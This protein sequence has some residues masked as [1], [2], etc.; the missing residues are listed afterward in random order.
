MSH[1]EKEKSKTK[2]A[3]RRSSAPSPNAFINEELG[4]SQYYLSYRDISLTNTDDEPKWDKEVSHTEFL[5]KLKSL[6]D[7][8]KASQSPVTTTTAV[9]SQTV[10]SNPYIETTVERLSEEDKNALTALRL[11]NKPVIAL[12]YQPN[13]IRSSDLQNRNC[14]Q[15]TPITI[16][17]PHY[18]NNKPATE[19]ASILNAT[20]FPLKAFAVS[21]TILA[22]ITVTT[23]ACYLSSLSSEKTK[24]AIAFQSKGDYQAALASA[25]LAA[26]CN[27]LSAD[28]YF[29]RGRAQASLLSFSKAEESFNQALALAPNDKN[30]LDARAALS[31][32]MKKPEQAIIDIKKLIVL[33][34]DK[35][36]P[37]QYG[38]LAIAYYQTGRQDEALHYY[39]LALKK[40]PQNES[41]QLGRAYTLAAKLQFKDSLSLCNKLL[42]KFPS[43]HEALALRGYCHQRLGALACAQEDMDKAVSL[44]PEF[45][46][47]YAYRAALALQKNNPKQALKDYTRLADLERDNDQA[48]HTAAKMLLDAGQKRE[49]QS[50]YKRLSLISSFR[51]TPAQVIEKANLDYELGSWQ[52][53]VKSFKTAVSV[54]PTAEL[55]EKLALSHAHL[56]QAHEARE[57][58][59]QALEI[60]TVTKADSHM[61][62]SARV[63]QILGNSITAIDKY[64]QILATSPGNT[65]ALVNRAGLY[66]KSEKWASAAED[67]QKARSLGAS[68]PQVT[69]NLQKCTSLLEK[70]SQIV[71]DLPKS[72]TMDMSILNNVQ[73]NQKASASYKAGE[74]QMAALYFG[75]MV[76]RNPTDLQAR[77]YLAHS[78]AGAGE[79]EKAI[80][81][82]NSLS[83]VSKLDTVDQLACA[84]ALAAIG[85][86]DQAISLMSEAQK[87][88]SSNLGI[89]LA[90]AKIL[91][92]SGKIDQAITLCKNSAQDNGSSQAGAELNNLY[93]SLLTQKQRALRN[94]R[95]QDNAV[96][97]EG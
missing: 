38:N 18:S 94:T 29:A 9:E 47:G 27:F 76:R 84:N 90:L 79:H 77:R 11:N 13:N 19:S 37:Y 41:I 44:A 61:L 17:T 46:R 31:I 96:S 87:G 83:A 93:Q 22:A 33:S 21:A 69:E 54:Q 60:S 15:A 78:L 26:K 56:G 40:D 25:S 91:S 34:G 59:A 52:E 64:S 86:Y 20:P 32:K 42:E 53:A 81:T 92:A 73:L 8:P 95:E 70:R 72:M 85:Q 7:T 45:A 65:D 48:Q 28:A 4:D 57:S 2:R 5:E 35:L 36:K 3:A 51:K 89:T 74:M 10:S 43:N 62:T 14:N 16:E 75:E 67:Y 30:I 97:T 68:Q 71:L 63:E 66:M 23:A 6:I 58:L 1:P 12:S 50:Y 49:A 82:F 55:Y 88:N 24:A 39:T 80:L